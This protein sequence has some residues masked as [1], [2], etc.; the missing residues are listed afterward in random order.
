MGGIGWFMPRYSKERKAAVLKK[1]L[2]PENRSVASVA[3]E[4]GI[5]N[6]TLYG[7]LKTCRQQGLPVPGKRKTGDE[8]SADAK[9]AV[10]IETAPLSETELGAYCREK[11]VYPE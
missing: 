11:G 9:L 1:L 10:V 7:W 8:W 5:A 3:A 2:P 6:A 4:E